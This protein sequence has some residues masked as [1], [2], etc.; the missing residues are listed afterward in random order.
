MRCN[1]RCITPE[2]IDRARIRGLEGVLVGSFMDFDLS[3]NLTLLDP[4]NESNDAFNGNLL[5]RRPEQTF[6]LDVDRAIGKF[7]AGGTLFAVRQP[8]R[9]RGQQGAL[10]GYTLLDLRASY[11]FNDALRIQARLENAFDEDYETVAW[12]NQPG[13]AFYLT[14]RYTP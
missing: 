7:A 2:N 8:L 13:R 12:Y 14:L 1:H 4:R 10:D 11:A 9:R 3:A 5:A 6:R